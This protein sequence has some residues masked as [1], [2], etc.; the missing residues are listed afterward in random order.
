MN[1]KFVINFFGPFAVS[2]GKAGRS[3][4]STVDDERP[5]PETSMKGLMRASA[6]QLLI[7]SQLV[8]E[9]FGREGSPS[10]WNWGPVTF[11]VQP[12]RRMRGRVSIDSETN[13]AKKRA[14]AFEEQ[15]WSGSASFDIQLFLPLAAN[16]RLLHEVI[17]KASAG[18]VHSFG[19]NR[20]RASGWVAIEPLEPWTQQNRELFDSVFSLYAQ[21][22]GP[23]ESPMNTTSVGAQ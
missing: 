12:V 16:E 7:P 15:H 10:P 22:V 18:A 2:T 21:P 11:A 6:K 19:K 14:L 20:R 9:V 3:A 1:L 13:T 23:N 8:N 17:L 4:D 5:L